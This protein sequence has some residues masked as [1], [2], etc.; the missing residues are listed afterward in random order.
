MQQY[1][2]YDRTQ[3]RDNDGLST[4]Y[5]AEAME[6]YWSQH[7][8]IVICRVCTI[9]V[10]A[11]P[12][13]LRLMR[14]KRHRRREQQRQREDE[15]NQ[16][17]DSERSEQEMKEIEDRRLFDEKALVEAATEVR[18]T[19]VQLGPVFIKLGQLLS[20]RPD[21]LPPPVLEE[22]RKLCDSVTAFSTAE[23]L[24]LIESELGRP[25]HEV[26]QVNIQ[27]AQLPKFEL[28]CIDVFMCCCYCCCW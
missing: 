13:V 6:A 21:V 20:S 7:K 1:A 25:A 9:A 16:Q 5:D 11:L 4:V 19:L 8:A 3:L 17:N 18:E 22:L 28:R 23:A 12:L 27:L 10:E 14:S 2:A 26:F 15:L 24:A